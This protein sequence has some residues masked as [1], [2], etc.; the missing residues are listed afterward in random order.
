MGIALASLLWPLM[1]ECCLA[2]T[3]AVTVPWFDLNHCHNM[4]RVLPLKQHGEDQEIGNFTKSG[5][6]FGS[7]V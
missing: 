2:L 1:S 5:S 6:T 3:C 7:A 4:A